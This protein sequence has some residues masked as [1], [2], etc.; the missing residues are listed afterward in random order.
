[1][2]KDAPTQISHAASPE[3]SASN[4]PTNNSTPSWQR[5]DE[6]EF[7]FFG[8]GTYVRAASIVASYWRPPF[9]GGGTDTFILAL[10]GGDSV[11]LTGDQIEAFLSWAQDRSIQIPHRSSS[12]Q[13]SLS[14]RT[15]QADQ[16][17]RG[18]PGQVPSHCDQPVAS[19]PPPRSPLLQSADLPPTNSLET[20]TA[21][22]S[23]SP[24][25]TDNP[26]AGGSFLPAATGESEA[27]GGK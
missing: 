8:K 26:T 3:K 4:Q 27:G 6:S 20:F 1:M 17:D 5:L 24:A 10:M 23:D 2:S 15:P 19:P 7:L 22:V 9:A 11:A 21:P 16:A 14:G 18:Q 13:S 12:L 25:G